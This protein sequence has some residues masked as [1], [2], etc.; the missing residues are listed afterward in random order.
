MGVPADAEDLR[1]RSGAVRGAGS[2]HAGIEHPD[3]RTE[4]NHALQPVD[5]H[6]AGQGSSGAAG[7]GSDLVTLEAVD[8]HPHIIATDM[9]RYPPAPLRGQQSDWS[10]QRPQTFEQLIAQMDDA[11]VAKAAIVQ[12]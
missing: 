6:V 4:E 5:R 3:W 1:R 10:K 8:I 2:V 9:G 11:G 12:A 7:V